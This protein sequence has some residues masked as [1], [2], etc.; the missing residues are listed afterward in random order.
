MIMSQC[1]TDWKKIKI[2]KG[3]SSIF[4]FYIGHDPVVIFKGVGSMEN[5][6]NQV[7]FRVQTISK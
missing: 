3:M 5:L 2:S 6:H 4:R 7:E 1:L